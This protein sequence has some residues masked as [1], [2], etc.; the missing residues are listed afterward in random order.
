MLFRSGRSSSTIISTFSGIDANGITVYAFDSRG[1]VGSETYN[2][3]FVEYI[4]LAFTS[5]E[6]DRTE[7]TST[8]VYFKIK[9]NYYNGSFGATS[10]TLSLKWRWRKV[11]DVWSS[12]INYNPTILENTFTF[13]A[14]SSLV[15]DNN[16]DYQFEVIVSD[17]LMTNVSTGIQLV[18]KGTGVIDIFEDEVNV[19]VPTNFILGDDTII[20]SKSIKHNNKLLSDIL[21]STYTLVTNANFDSIYSSNFDNGIKLFVINGG[22]L[23]GAPQNCYKWGL[24]INFGVNNNFAVTQIYIEDNIGTITSRYIYVRIRNNSWLRLTGTI[25]AKIN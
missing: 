22:T 5:I 8:T 4:K 21:G 16:F 15:F 18:K 6:I 14:Q 1:W 23:I 25:I 13:E 17:K 3:T 2:P 20:N 12:Y 10:N 24:L 11:G 19:N 9:G 7:S